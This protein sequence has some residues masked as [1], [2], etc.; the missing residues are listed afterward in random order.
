MEGKGI[1]YE[2][3]STS[4]EVTSKLAVRVR[5]SKGNSYCCYHDFPDENANGN[6][7]TAHSLENK[8]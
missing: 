2:V 4:E 7:H 6:A 5:V 1:G 3:A 8:L